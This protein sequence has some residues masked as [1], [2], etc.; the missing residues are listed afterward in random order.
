MSVPLGVCTN[1][2]CQQHK[3]DYVCQTHNLHFCARLQNVNFKL[4]VVW[5]HIESVVST[6]LTEGTD[7]QQLSSQ[8][9]LQ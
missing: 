3:F 1:T 8:V 2:T 6:H 7:E 4:K 5:K 9:S